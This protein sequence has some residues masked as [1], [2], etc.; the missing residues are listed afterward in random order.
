MGN[1]LTFFSH[2]RM[3]QQ[4]A[5][6]CDSDATEIARIFFE[7]TLET[8]FECGRV[9]KQQF[10][11]RFEEELGHSVDFERL[12]HA[13]SD[14]FR[15]NEEILPVLD[16]LKSR[17]I[18]LIVLSN[19]N[20]SHVDFIRAEFDLLHRFDDYVFSHEAGAM[21]P[22][23]AIYDV[24]LS[25]ANCEANECF[26]TD[27]IE[28]YILAAREFNIQAEVF[29]DVATLKQHLTDRGAL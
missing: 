14:I 20:A 4:D 27:D 26:Y 13:G 18:R 3:C 28:A 29:T 9:S 23:A 2:E 22:D 8:D 1:V 11:Q 7:T 16:E 15:L 5:E 24:A 25:K 19:T 21:K 6:V 10:H 12:E 17:G